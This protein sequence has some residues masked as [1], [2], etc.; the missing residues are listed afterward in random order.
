MNSDMTLSRTIHFLA[1]LFLLVCAQ[2]AFGQTRQRVIPFPEWSAETD[3]E[4]QLELIEIK[5]AGKPVGFGEFFEANENWL[6]SITL[7]V[8][9][10]SKKTIVAFGVGGGL[11]AGLDEELPAHTSFQFGVAWNWGKSLD[12]KKSQ[13]SVLFQPGEILEL[14]YV[15]VDGL[16]RQVLSKEGEGSFCKLK[17]MA[18]AIKFEDGS[19]VLAPRMLFHAAH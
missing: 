17:F 1:V 3:D 4:Y 5:V 11:L 8:K 19:S 18:P 12:P 7:K 2:V 9:N 15:H 6:S 10:V 16:T 13:P 14:S